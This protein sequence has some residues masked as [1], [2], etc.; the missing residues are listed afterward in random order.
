MCIDTS[1]VV[2][3]SLLLPFNEVATVLQIGFHSMHVLVL[4]LH[5]LTFIN[6]IFIIRHSKVGKINYIVYKNA[7]YQSNKK[8]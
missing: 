7:K 3:S 4:L 8:R 6:C 2:F 5:I 1:N